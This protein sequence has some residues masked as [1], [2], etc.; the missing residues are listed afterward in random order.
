MPGQLLCPKVLCLEGP[1]MSY[2]GEQNLG[3]SADP[4]VAIGPD[5]DP[6]PDPG[7]GNT[8]LFECASAAGPQGQLLFKLIRENLRRRCH[9]AR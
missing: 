2:Q 6:N 9:A 8:I 4:A 5:S 1:F 3:R 7:S